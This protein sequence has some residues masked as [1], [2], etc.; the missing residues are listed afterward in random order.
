MT[1]KKDW[2]RK[3]LRELK[4]GKLPMDNFIIKWEA[5]YLQAEVNNS[6]MVELLE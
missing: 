1:N 3:E 6:H 4:Q 5:L 2:G